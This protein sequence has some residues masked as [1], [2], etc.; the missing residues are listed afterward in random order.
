MRTAH[1]PFSGVLLGVLEGM[2]Q[3]ECVL[4]GMCPEELG[5]ARGKQYVPATHV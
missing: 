3:R 5:E 4:E 2:H 1:I